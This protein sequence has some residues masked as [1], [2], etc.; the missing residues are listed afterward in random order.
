MCTGDL[1]SNQLTYD[2]VSSVDEHTT[3]THILN[4]CFLWNIWSEWWFMIIT[5]LHLDKYWLKSWL[6]PTDMFS[7]FLTSDIGM[8]PCNRPC[9]SFTVIFVHFIT[10]QQPL[11]WMCVT[12]ELSFSI[13]GGSRCI[14][15]VF[16][17]SH[18]V[19]KLFLCYHDSIYVQ[20]LLQIDTSCY[21]WYKCICETTSLPL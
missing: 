6:G 16:L 13:T 21:P 18:Y 11:F 2:P 10:S 8:V 15:C 5:P 17:F 19:S 14:S 12:Q 9:M 4:I 7:S 1:T 3:F 20:A